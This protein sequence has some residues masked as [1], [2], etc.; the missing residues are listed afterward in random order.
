MSRR[1]GQEGEK[2]SHFVTLQLSPSFKNIQSWKISTAGEQF[3]IPVRSSAFLRSLLLECLGANNASLDLPCL[4]APS[5]FISL[6]LSLSVL[7]WFLRQGLAMYPA[8][9]D[10][11]LLPHLPEC[12]DYKH[13]PPYPTSISISYL[14]LSLQ[15]VLC[16]AS[17]P[18]DIKP[19]FLR[20]STY[21]TPQNTYPCLKL[22]GE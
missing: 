14:C 21:L 6:S 20:L 12:W 11:K 4:S 9:T 22:M 18:T 19:L 17:L 7:S 5:R 10:L 2:N 3:A 8:Q 13:W 1:G 16:R 15:V